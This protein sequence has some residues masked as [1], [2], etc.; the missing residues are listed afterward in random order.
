MHGDGVANTEL[1]KTQG[2]QQP[3]K[4]DLQLVCLDMGD[5]LVLSR[6][7]KDGGIHDT[8]RYTNQLLHWRARG[9]HQPW[10]P[11]DTRVNLSHWKFTMQKTWYQGNAINDISL[12][13]SC[14]S[15]TV[16]N[17]LLSMFNNAGAHEAALWVSSFYL[18]DTEGQQGPKSHSQWGTIPEPIVM[19]PMTSILN[20]T[21]AQ[22]MHI[23]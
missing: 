10:V 15:S 18:D 20:N 19:E 7:L 4:M 16:L 8:K 6:S 12:S 2:S 13:P 23:E 1:T 17:T 11:A 5:G 3:R 9:K 14:A 22:K 21:G